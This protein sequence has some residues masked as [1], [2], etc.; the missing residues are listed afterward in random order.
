MPPAARPPAFSSPVTMS[1]AGSSRSRNSPRAPE[2]VTHKALSANSGAPS[3][4]G[5]NVF[6]ALTVPVR[7]SSRAST[8]EAAPARGGAASQ[9]AYRPPPA[10]VR[11]RPAAGI[12]VKDTSTAGRGGGACVT[13]QPAIASAVV[14]NRTIDVSAA[15]ERILITI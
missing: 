6:R 8:G 1:V 11:V 12:P 3:S 5:L 9:V 4:P 10:S 2:S 14:I 7:G 15:P 13:P